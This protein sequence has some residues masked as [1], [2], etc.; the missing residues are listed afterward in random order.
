MKEERFR[1]M[2]AAFGTVTDCSLKFTKDGKFRKFGF[3]GFKSEEEANSALQHFHKSFVDTSRVT[4][5]MCKAFGDPTKAK[6]WSK[7][8]QSSGQDKAPASAD[9]DKNKKNKKEKKELNST[10]D[11]LEEDQGFKEFLSVH[12]NRSQAPTWANDTLQQTT[13]DSERTK[14]QGKKKPASDDYLNF[15]SDQSEDEG[16]EYV[17]DE[18]TT[19]GA[20]ESGLSDMDYLRS[21]VAQ[22]DE[23]ME[24]GE[25]KDDGEG[26]DDEDEDR[27]AVQQHADSAYESGDRDNSS[28]TKT[29]AS[30]EDKKQ[31]KA[32]KTAKQEM[33]PTT[34]FTVKLRGA[35]F[36]VKEQQI[37]EFMTPLKPAAI[38]IGKNESGNRTGYVY[39]DL[40]SEEEVG[41]A[42]KKNKDYIGGRYIEVF[43]VDANR[44]KGQRDIKEKE[45]DRNFTRQL[46]EDEEEED[47]A[48]S[49][50]LFIRNLPYT[51]T[52]EEIK[53][54]FSKHGPLSEV[55]FPID[56][57]T[58]KPK[59]FAFI[60][61]MIPENAVTALAK[62]DGHI[63]Q[64]RM[65]HLLPSTVKKEKAESSDAGGPGSSSYKRQKDAKNKAS[66]SSSHNW[67]SLFLGTSAVADAIAEKYNTT[68]SQV[69][70]H[71]SKGSV[72]VRMALG[73]TQ[74]VQETRQFLLDNGVS[75]DS[76]SQ[77]AAERS[78]TVI[79]VKNLPAGV[80]VSELEELFSPHG[81]LGRVLLPP[82]GLTAIIEFLEPPEAKRAFTRLAYSKFHHVPLYLEWAPVGVFV[83]AKLEPVLDKEEAVKEEKEEEEDEDEEEESAPG[84][85]LF[86]KNLNFSTT[87]ETLQET[88]SKCGKITSCTISK[89]KDKTGKLLSMGYGFVQYQM[90]EAAQKALRQLQHCTVDDHQLELKISERATRTT[91][92]SRKKKQVDK[93]QT[94]SKILVRNVPFQASVREIRELFCTFGELKTVRLPK[95]A[96][97]SGKH[98]GFG[99]IDFLTKQDAKRAFA[100]LCH[101]THLYGRRLVLEWADAEETVETLRRKTAEHFHA[102]IRTAVLDKQ[103]GQL[104]VLEGFREDFVA[105]ANFTDDIA[106]SGWSFLE[107]TTSNKYNDSIQ[108]YAAGAVEAAVTSQLIY[109]HWMNTLM[110]YCGPFTSQTGYCARLKAFITANLQWAQ[111][112][113]EKQPNSPYWYQVRLAL[114]QLKGLEDSYNDELSFP[115]GPLSFNPFGFLLFQLGG[116]LEDLE[117]ALNKSS[118]TRPL[119]SGSCS[120]LIKLL[121]N[122]KELLVSHDTWN[123]YQSMLR[124]M[125]KYIFAFSVSPLANDLLPGGTQAFSSY[126][127]SIFSGD[128]FYILSSGLV[129]LETTIGN[130]N[131]ALWK[132]VQPIGTIMEWLRNIVA[133]RLAATGK[134]WAEI[135]SK[136]NS[137]TYNNQ[138]MI[139]DYNH[140]TPGL[141]DM[142]EDLFVVLEQI[143]GFIVYTDKTQE[144]L[145]K[146]YWASYNIPY[147]EEIFNASGCN[148]LV[149]KF[150]PWFSL[151]Q[152]PRAQLFRRN[153]TDVTDV[154][155]MVRLMSRRLELL[156]IRVDSNAARRVTVVM[157]LRSRKQTA[158]SC[159]CVSGAVAELYT[160][161]V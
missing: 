1:S 87:E 14:T 56:N 138:W 86:I 151:D 103:S 4:V 45:I 131:P 147:Y 37:K 32:K 28:K 124:I 156:D 119:G 25:E 38:R 88:F 129:T 152:N 18:G 112:Q 13:P 128:D 134:E 66:S 51:C 117:S 62:L 2:F 77:A 160:M 6:A 98:R 31:R 155:S 158:L 94:G 89:K 3:V 20:L 145:E 9:T 120:A 76:F 85:T 16:E 67:N 142:K 130:S 95:K 91:E 111:D 132:F 144:L 70:D 12:Q 105:W 141:P 26:G 122:N 47:V 97:G 116:D 53:E 93:K 43:C 64:G 127:G 96:A 57:L 104:S 139:V 125:K 78:T 21:K 7:H 75:L 44:G 40:R 159:L 10:L 52:E 115:V 71:E 153:Q 126:P 157:A 113:I 72:A 55:L 49:G 108:A 146:G 42:L 22:T 140:F 50:R 34:E 114:L 24:Q 133:N 150:G 69:L 148:E 102:E 80:V 149:E 63:F 33:E 121:P 29:S 92:V 11:N 54:L 46:K 74:I 136:Y 36:N 99:F 48:E 61:Y 73:E 59:G 23:T 5:E 83:A 110:G 35:P 58:K 79:L 143:P 65:I 8:T 123:T 60:T 137:G 107:V 17:E 68:K 154:D 41:K 15:D 82:S 109:K 101:S 39:V 161:Y 90:A 84:S 118:Q 135:F 106:K 30:S 100:A 81:S 19:K 27:G